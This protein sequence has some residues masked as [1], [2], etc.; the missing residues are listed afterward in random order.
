[1][2]AD[3]RAVLTKRSK[4]ASPSAAFERAAD[5]TR[6]QRGP[7]LARPPLAQPPFTI[8]DL[9]DCIP[10]HCFER[11]YL[12]SFGHLALDALKV[13]ALAS[14][15]WGFE[16]FLAPALPAWATYTF[17]A[18]YVYALGCVLTGV[19]VLAHECGHQAFSPSK[20][21]NDCVGHVL[22]TLLLVPYHAWRVSHGKHHAHTGSVEDDEVFVPPTRSEVGEHLASAPLANLL[23]IVNMLLLGWPGYLIFNLSG[24]SKYHRPNVKRSHFEPDAALFSPRDRAG[25]LAGNVSLALTLAVLT[26]LTRTLGW[27]TMTLHY[28]LPYL[29]VNAHLV[30]ITYLQHTDVHV[31]HFAGD[32]WNWMRGALATVDRSFGSVL[33]H[34]FHRIADLHVCHHIFSKMPFYHH[35]EATRAMR[36]ILG[37]YYLRDDTPIV[38]A[39]WRSWSH[40]KFVEDEGGVR[41]YKG[42][43]EQ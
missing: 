9:R 4:T 5:K 10:P 43:L 36:P 40:C 34:T 2:G 7:A 30:L 27:R 41:F 23:G 29:V 22:H 8:K 6:L 33:D 12:R 1:M 11:S 17:Y 42:R 26:Y 20:V 15:Y 25:I 32:D 38:M 18:A 3:Q 16:A 35:E 28:W 37:Q 24:P 19:W 14:L 21:V 13:A 39:L 31:P